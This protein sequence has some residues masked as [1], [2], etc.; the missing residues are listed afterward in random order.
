M[1]R[2]E[3]NSITCIITQHWWK[4]GTLVEQWL[5][6]CAR[7][8]KVAGSIPAMYGTLNFISRFKKLSFPYSKK[9]K[10]AHAL[11]PYFLK[12]YSNIMFPSKPRSFKR[13]FPPTFSHQ[14]SFCSPPPLSRLCHV[15]LH[16]LPWF[17]HPNNIWWG[18]KNTKF[19][20]KQ[21]SPVPC[22]L[23]SPRLKYLPQHQFCEPMFFTQCD[24][25][26]YK[27]KN[28]YDSLCFNLNRKWEN[29]WSWT[30]WS[31]VFPKTKLPL[32]FA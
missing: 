27:T 28:N 24:S 12:I 32:I 17:D 25:H 9:I 16:M 3:V 29:T 5:W 1:C 15:P 10:P 22:Y 11:P 26:Q 4:L 19:F 31:Q 13:G 23:S 8:Q 30:K 18:V 7:N 20:F 21:F 6:C 14:N 2:S